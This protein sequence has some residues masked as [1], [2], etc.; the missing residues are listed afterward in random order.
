MHNPRLQ[1]LFISESSAPRGLSEETNLSVSRP[2]QTTHEY[3]TNEAL[4]TLPKPRSGNDEYGGSDGYLKVYPGDRHDK[5]ICHTSD[6]SSSEE[7][8]GNGIPLLPF[9]IQIFYAC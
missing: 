5:D 1:L 7:T 4:S 3:N 9:T 8:D 6:G 2:L